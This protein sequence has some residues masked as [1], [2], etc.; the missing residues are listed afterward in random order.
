MFRNGGFAWE[1]R[2]PGA[3]TVGFHSTSRPAGDQT[4]DPPTNQKEVG[5]TGELI[6]HEETHAWEQAPVPQWRTKD[7]FEK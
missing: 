3:L 5:G 4:R 2:H 1:G 7:T 6:K